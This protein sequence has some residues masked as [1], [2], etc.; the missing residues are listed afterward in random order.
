M[1]VQIFLGIHLKRKSKILHTSS[2]RQTVDVLLATFNGERYLEEQLHSLDQQ[3]DVNVHVWAND[4][5]SDDAT[6]AILIK[7]QKLGLI[8]DITKTQRIGSTRA[9]LKLLSEHSNSEYVAFCDQDD[10]WEPI[11]LITQLGKLTDESPMLV[12]SQ[13]LYINSTGTI[14]G[15]SR[16]LRT[17]PC[18]E[19]AIVENIAPGNTILMN[20]KAIKLINSF[21]NPAIAHYDSWIYLLITAFGK[22]EF[23]DLRLVMY[24]IHDSNLVGLRKFILHRFISSNQN[25]LNQA[26]FFSEMVGIHLDEYKKTTLED[27]VSIFQK[28]SKFQKSLQLLNLKVNRQ[29]KLDVFG[30]K[31]IFILL[32]LTGKV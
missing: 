32:V 6:L 20:N 26:K 23:L 13:R 8:K 27:F 9:F 21:P 29:S 5:G 15:K 24:R 4:D 10:I 11:K 22:V 2:N 7:W 25:Y 16:A 3:K 31:A 19:N 17:P 28:K 30:I 12:A 1:Q 14:T 18:F